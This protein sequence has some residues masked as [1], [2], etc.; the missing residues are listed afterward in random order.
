MVSRWSY[1]NLLL[2]VQ[3]A[4]EDER[5]V[6]VL[7]YLFEYQNLHRDPNLMFSTLIG[8]ESFLLYEI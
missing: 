4:S 6:H 7:L 1:S 2:D 3:L 5:E 8:T